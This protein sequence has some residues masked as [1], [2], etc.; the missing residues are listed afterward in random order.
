MDDII[1]IVSVMEPIGHGD[2]EVC[3]LSTQSQ[4]EAVK[5]LRLKLSAMV[6]AVQVFVLLVLI[7]VSI[8]NL[9]SGNGN[10]E[11]WVALLSTSLGILLPSPNIKGKQ[12]PGIP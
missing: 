2:V 8:Y 12:Q 7:T 5:H 10:K 1:Y 9:S 6:F 4:C 3:R 11:L